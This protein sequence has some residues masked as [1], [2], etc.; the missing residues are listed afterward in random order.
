MEPGH[1]QHPVHPGRAHQRHHQDRADVHVP[2]RDRGQPGVVGPRHTQRHPGGE[3][4]SRQRSLQRHPPTGQHVGADP[5]RDVDPQ[6]RPV[7]GGKHDG[8]QVGAADLPGALG[9]QV[10]RVAGILGVIDGDQLSRDR[11]GRLQPLAAGAGGL[12][13]TGV[14]DGHRRGRRQRVGQLLV[15]GG[16]PAPSALG[17][18]E[19]AEHLVTDPDR[20]AQEAV[21]GRMAGGEARRARVVGDARQP[22]RLG[23]LDQRTQQPL[24]LRQVPDPRHRFRGHAH[25]YE[26]GQSTGRRDHPQRCVPRADQLPRR[27]RDPPQQHRQRQVPDHHLVRPQQPPQPPLGGHHLLRPLHQ[28]P[29]QLVELQA[30]QIGEGQPDGLVG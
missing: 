16:E 2:G 8:D 17:E 4:L 13:Q 10:Q 18:V 3:H 1:R 28:L 22:D 19:V 7:G 26:L 6:P 29:Q 20:H 23:I 30:R 12:V 15:L 11:R 25:V 27:V 24:A 5:D 14:L 9:D 21:H